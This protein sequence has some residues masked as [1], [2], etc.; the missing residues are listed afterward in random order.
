MNRRKS[1][2]QPAQKPEERCLEL[3]A[4]NRALAEREA[5]LRAVFDAEPECVKLLAADGSLLD[6]NPAG[7]RMIEADSL[8]QVQNRNVMPLVAEEHRAAFRALTERVMGG[9]PGRLEY[10]IT[11][12][13]GARRWVE[14]HASPLR[15]AAGRVTALLGVTRDITERR[16]AEA[17]LRLFRSLIERVKDAIEVIDPVTGRFLDIN[18]QGCLDLG[19]ARAEMLSKT[20]WEINPTVEPATFA[21]HVAATR[22]AG[23]LTF[24]SVHRRRDGTVFPVEIALTFI[25]NERDYLVGVVRDITERKRAETALRESE[26][27]LNFSLHMS[28]TGGWDLDLVDHTAYRT[29]EHDRIFGYE[30]LL[31]EWTY[32]MFLEHVFPEDRAEVDRRFRAATAVQGD[33][34]FECRIRRRDGEVRW[35]FAAGGHQRDAAG[36]AWRVAGIV[37]DITERKQ[38]EEALRQSEE[39]KA[40]IFASALDALVTIDQTG[41]VEEWNPAAERIFGYRREEAVGR[42]L[43]GM[44]IP[45][46]LREA[47]RQGMARVLSGGESHVLRRLLEMPALRADGTEF[48]VELFIT[49]IQKEP[50]LFTGFIRDI[51][52]RRRLEEQ[53][54]QSQK[55]EA[56]GQLAGGVAHDFNNILG[57]IMGNADLARADLGPAHPGRECLDEIGAAAERAAGLTR[58]LLLFSRRQVMEPRLLDLNEVVTSLTKM[59][60]RIIGEDVQ[61]QLHLHSRPL[62]VHADAGMLDQVLMN[63][64]VNARD[65]MPG[66]G[67]L[68]IETTERELTAADAAAIPD[69]APGRYACLRVT[70]SGCGIAPADLARIFEPFFTTKEVGK[71]TGLGLATVFGIVKQHGGALQV[72]S[73]PGRGTAFQIL[74]PAATAADES[75]A[76]KAAKPKP[77]GGTETVLVVEDEPSL[78]MLT[79]IIL[80]QAGYQVLEA[81]HGVEALEVWERHPGPIHLLF[82][83]LVMPEGVSGREL[84]ARLRER[85]PR[86]PVIFTSGYSAD[87]AGRELALQPGQ[88]F[89]QKPSRPHELLETV[90]R[91]LDS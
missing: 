4:A 63:L 24:E 55:M 21:Q 9:E 47:H 19:Y 91:C 53:F 14:T 35:I 16:Q 39:R 58:Q 29:L 69:A 68:V 33:W 38:A 3:E 11:T 32:E 43:A 44:I 90:R 87:I 71:G 50:P 5:R 17:S 64:V 59:L 78:R 85:Y 10:Q 20:V 60:Q 25:Q 75:V 81:A 65:A 76:E 12:L 66:G 72:E 52:G 13:K 1:S 49:P 88:H 36:Q 54:R 31:P 7:L 77:R 84:A 67:R 46:R 45:P 57:V 28:H 51:T 74:L 61:Q 56:I 18:E 73:E 41:T 2:A 80:E 89:L 42:E 62:T 22:Q 6:M 27:R 82:T 70:D 8:A 23:S 15:D 30:E 34:S 79:R 48:P 83:D 40:A 86:L 37:Q 26:Q